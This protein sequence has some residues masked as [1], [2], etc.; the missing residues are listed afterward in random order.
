M[1]HRDGSSWRALL[2]GPLRRHFAELLALSTFINILALAAPIFTL[3]VY[4]RVISFA[5]LTTLEGLVIG[6]GLVL[7]F[8]FVLRQSRAR[9][10]QRV[11]LQIDAALGRRLFGKLMS[12]PLRVL[13]ARPAVSWQMLFRDLE[14]VRNVFSGASALLLVDMPFALLF[15]AMVYVLAPPIAWVLP[16]ILVGFL[17][18]SIRSGAVLSARHAGENAAAVGR[19]GLITEIVAGRTTVKALALSDPLRAL[20][21]ERHAATIRESLARGMHTD[22]YVNLGVALSVLTTVAI[23]AIGAVA[24]IDQKIT[25]GSLIA[26][27]MLSGRIV[28]SFN[29]LFVSWKSYALCRQSMARLAEAFALPEDRRDSAV[30][31][32]RPSGELVLENVTFH[33]GDPRRKAIDDVSLAIPATGMTG[34]V[35][36]NGS[37][38]TTLLKLLQGLYAPASGRVLLDGAD[39]AQ[40]T[41]RELSGWI[42]YVPQDCVLLSGTVRDNIARHDPGVTDAEVVAAAQRAGAHQ[43]ILD[44]P[45]GYATQIGEA[46]G[47]LSSGQRQRL[48]IARALVKDPPVLVLDEPTAFLD[49]QMEFEFRQTL[50]ALARDHTIIMVTHS[51]PLLAACDR[52]VVLDAGRVTMSG[53]AGEVLPRLTQPRPATVARPA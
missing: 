8:D 5:G 30:A 4:D 21:E 48:A 18:L 49:R 11:A 45:D 35:G 17:A 29:Q 32:S 44:L 16:V 2:I 38:K 9:L 43:A 39:L 12:A 10:L 1:D 47:R 23:T 50:R 33:Y 7:A 22:T 51:G 20:W 41:R 52:I 46:G 27:N 19:D 15:L 14:L 6:M 53:P 24:I 37:G 31:L 25:L 34:L 42:G 36:R 13:E 26:I 28:A 40:F 3:Q